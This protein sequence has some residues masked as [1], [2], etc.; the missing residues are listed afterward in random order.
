V[1]AGAR[2]LCGWAGSSQNHPTTVSHFPFFFFCPA[3]EIGIKKYQNGKI[4]KLIFLAFL[5]YL[6][7]NKN[8]FMIFGLN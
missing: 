4:V 8:S 2:F 3:L 7:F 6:E 5:F 1:G